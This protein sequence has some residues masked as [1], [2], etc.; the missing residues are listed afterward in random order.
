[1]DKAL[2][3]IIGNELL[4]GD[5]IDTNSN[6]IEKSI[7]SYKLR[8]DRVCMLPDNLDDIKDELLFGLKKA[9]KFIFITGGLG[10]TEDDLTREA[11]AKALDLDLVKD[12]EE[13]N[14]IKNIFDTKKW[15]F[16]DN[17]AKQSLFPKGSTILK[18]DYGTASA[19]HIQKDGVNIISLPGV[20]W[21]TR[22]IWDKRVDKIISDNCEKIKTSERLIVKLYDIGESKVDEVIVRN[23]MI[24]DKCGYAITAAPR[25]INVKISFPADFNELDKIKDETLKNF[26]NEFNRNF[27]SSTDDELM[28]IIHNMLINNKLTISTA[29]SC[30][31]GYL[32]K[33][34]T[35]KPGSSTYYIGSAITYANEA[36]MNLLG[37]SEETLNQFGAVSEETCREMIRGLNKLYKTQYLYCSLL[38]LPVL[39]EDLKQKPTG[40]VYIGLSYNE[41]EIIITHNLIPGIRDVV[42]ERT[43]YKSLFMIYQLGKR[44]NWIQY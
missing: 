18:N 36:K 21:E 22:K 8:V 43:A 15:G 29:E 42:R 25:G 32:S 11:I 9:Y 28:D 14:R 35:D 10:P 4:I 26:K 17:N 34:L 27:F 7:S 13:Y 2:I 31:G 20:P 23:K 30:T 38:V 39:M 16:T 3:I 44:K 19:F 6:F 12:D 5:I 33:M 24:P 37:V 1:M 41:K 40:T